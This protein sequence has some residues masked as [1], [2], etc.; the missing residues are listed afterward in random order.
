MLVKLIYILLFAAF[1]FVIY[2]KLN[3]TGKITP[4]LL[5]LFISIFIIFLILH[6]GLFNWSFLMDRKDFFP[7]VIL[8]FGPVIVYLWFNFLVL[9]RIKRLNMSNEEFR[10]TAIKIFSFFFLKFFYVMVFIVQCA[11][12]FNPISSSH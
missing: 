2:S 9:K 5:W 3:K 6:T 4:N 7:I 1:N 11:F 10:N 8:L 12:I